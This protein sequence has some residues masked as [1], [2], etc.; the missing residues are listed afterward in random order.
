M[1][2]RGSQAAPYCQGPDPCP[3]KPRV[4]I[5]PGTTDTHFHILGPAATYP[6]GANREYTPPDALPAAYRHLRETLGVERVVLVQPSVYGLDH[7]CILKS[8]SQLGVPAKMVVVV[9]LN[10]SD[11]ELQELHDA[12]ARAVRFILAHPGGLPLTAL[13]RFS[14]RVKRLG[15]H[16]QFLLRPADLID[17]ESSLSTL[18]SD[19]V[20]D[21]IGLIRASEGG[22]GQAAFQALLRLFR[23]GRCWIK[24]TGGYRISSE[25]PPYREV[26]PLV[27]ALLEERP[28]R[29]LWGSD[30]PHVMVRGGMPNTTDLLDLLT[31]WVPDEKVRKQILVDNPQTLFGF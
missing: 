31:E 29:L 28:D 30:W 12:G 21:H 3:R 10:T 2:N 14:E 24:L 16:V 27:S 18:A 23:I 22:V 26:I 17:L 8:A 5:P 7:R 11:E 9:P 6:Y 4:A 15:W 20:I 13:H 19:F 1:T 25:Q